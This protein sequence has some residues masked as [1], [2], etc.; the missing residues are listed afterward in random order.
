MEGEKTDHPPGKERV[1]LSDFEIGKHGD[2]NS[3][4]QF[5]HAVERMFA[6]QRQAGERQRDH[7]E[8]ENAVVPHRRRALPLGEA[9]GE[10]RR[11]VGQA[12]GEAGDGEEEDHDPDGLVPGEQLD[13]CRALGH[14]AEFQSE[15]DLGDDQHRADPVDRN[16]DAGVA[17]DRTTRRVVDHPVHAVSFKRAVV[18]RVNLP[19]DA[20]LSSSN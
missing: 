15:D 17:L 7:Q 5:R 10:S 20:A 9:F 8:V 3:A 4:D 16:R 12:D 14:V 18:Q 13:P 2:R 6:D 1:A 19:P 11:L